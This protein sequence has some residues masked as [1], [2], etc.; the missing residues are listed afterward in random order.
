M[1]HVLFGGPDNGLWKFRTILACKP[2]RTLGLQGWLT[3][4][5]KQG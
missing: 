2:E 4:A 3:S 5:N 1:D